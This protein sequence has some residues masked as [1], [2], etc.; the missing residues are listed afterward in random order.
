VKSAYGVVKVK[1]IINRRRRAVERESQ[2]QN[3]D[4]G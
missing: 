4:E 3:L 1:N 2:T